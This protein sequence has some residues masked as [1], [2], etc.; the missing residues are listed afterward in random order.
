VLLP[1]VIALGA[2]GGD[3]VS[4]EDYARDLDEVCSDLEEQTRAIGQVRP[5]NPRELTEQLD[6]IRVAI[7]DGIQRLRDIERPDGDDGERAAEYLDRVASD[8]EDQL[9]PA[10]DEL[11]EAVKA[12]DEIKVRAAAARLQSIDDRKTEALARDLGAD[13]C[14]EG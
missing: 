13:G 8:F 9:V 4:K 5:D 6:K 7:R 10:L 1:S 3:G 12:K 14:A 11:A 2:C